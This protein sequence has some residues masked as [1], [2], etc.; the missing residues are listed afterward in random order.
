MAG[1][2]NF[3]WGLLPAFAA[4]PTLTIV[5]APFSAAHPGGTQLQSVARVT[6][7][8]GLGS[9]S[10]EDPVGLQRLLL[11]CGLR[12]MTV[13]PLHL[14]HARLEHGFCAIV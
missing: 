6:P 7:G 13:Q 10:P 12:Y 2:G 9:T 1:K 3:Y 11:R 8:G 4:R 5:H 14:A